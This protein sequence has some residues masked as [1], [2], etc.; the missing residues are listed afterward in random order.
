M[1]WL[2]FLFKKI[3]N[4]I[5]NGVG[6]GL[7]KV[8]M[9]TS[10]QVP[11]EARRGCQCNYELPGV[12]ARSLFIF[13]KPLSLLCSPQTFLIFARSCWTVT[14]CNRK[15]YVRPSPS[16]T[17]KAWAW[18]QVACI[19]AHRTNGNGTS[20]TRE[21]YVSAVPFKAW[22]NKLHFNVSNC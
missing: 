12:S 3:L 21:L 13:F 10:V 15:T 9:Y 14:F 5:F 7:G 4:F 2:F 20:H 8:R 16:T 6:A 11:R 17:I 22:C 19:S 1:K 18:P